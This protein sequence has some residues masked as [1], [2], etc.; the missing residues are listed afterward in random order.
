MN[1]LSVLSFKNWSQLW[2]RLEM[3]RCT[4]ILRMQSP[5]RFRK[6]GMAQHAVQLV[7]DFLGWPKVVHLSFWAQPIRLVEV[8]RMLRDLLRA[9][10]VNFFHKSDTSRDF[11]VSRRCKSF[12]IL[13]LVGN[14][15]PESLLFHWV[16]NRLFSVIVCVLH[17]YLWLAQTIAHPFWRTWWQWR[18]FRLWYNILILPCSNVV[19]SVVLL[20]KLTSWLLSLVRRC[21]NIEAMARP[22]QVILNLIDVERPY[23][24]L[25]SRNLHFYI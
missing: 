20:L 14:G 9:W 8:I 23:L 25:A 4:R 13:W 17:F 11:V 7:L 12:L 5:L 21:L 19:G 22:G 2:C 6:H 16:V 1:S 24:W 15:W 3:T 10:L 18:K